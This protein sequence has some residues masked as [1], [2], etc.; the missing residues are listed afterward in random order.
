[1]KK[2][3]KGNLSFKKE[4]K[5][6]TYLRLHFNCHAMVQRVQ[7]PAQGLDLAP[8]LFV[9]PPLP[10]PGQR[11]GAAEG[12]LLH[13]PRT[14]NPTC[15]SRT[16]DTGVARVAQHWGRSHR[17]VTPAADRLDGLVVWK[18]RSRF[19]GQGWILIYHLLQLTGGNAARGG[20]LPGPS[21]VKTQSAG[22]IQ[23]QY[24]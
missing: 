10:W 5:I 13:Q 4:K 12:L 18:D 15:Q 20:L 17:D 3:L 22:P 6:T 9:L 21:L 23:G 2:C 1:M 8:K 7:A 16:G 14:E 19:K 11:P 24:Y